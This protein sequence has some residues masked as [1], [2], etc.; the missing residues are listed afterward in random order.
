M[1]WQ[2]EKKDKMIN[3]DIHYTENQRSSNTIPNLNRD[4]TRVLQKGKQFLLH[5]RHPSCYSC[6]KRGDKSLIRKGPGYDYDNRN[7]SEVICAF[8]IPV[9][10]EYCYI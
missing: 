1:Q 3:N 6:C 9:L 10:L 8:D 5:M 4:W 2:K 7:M